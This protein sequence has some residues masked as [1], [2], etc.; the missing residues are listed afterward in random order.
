MVARC[1]TLGARTT[2]VRNGAAVLDGRVKGQTR[3][4]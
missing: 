2:R 3:E 1:E 4:V